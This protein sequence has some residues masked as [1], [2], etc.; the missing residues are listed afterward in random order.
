L[1]VIHEIDVS[2]GFDMPSAKGLPANAPDFSAR[3]RPLQ[4]SA[5]KRIAQLP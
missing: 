2:A 5:R 4:F 1:F 3:L